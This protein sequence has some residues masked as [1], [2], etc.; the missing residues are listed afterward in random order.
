VIG[1]TH[2]VQCEI[3]GWPAFKHY[4][5]EVHDGAFVD[6]T[7]FRGYRLLDSHAKMARG[8]ETWVEPSDATIEEREEIA[9]RA[10][11]LVGRP[12]AYNL[13][14]NNCEHVASWCATG[15]AFSR[16]VVEGTRKVAGAL[17]MA[18]GVLLAWLG[19]ALISA[20]FAD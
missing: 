17:N 8:R 20:A 14:V 19:L 5:T 11:S 18:A 13:L 9:R 15:V 6:N 16:Q 10:E 3:L 4:A 7:F 12:Y 1:D 2:V